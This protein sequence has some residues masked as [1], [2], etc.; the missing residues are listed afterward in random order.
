MKGL[1]QVVP[2]R[3]QMWA[4]GEWVWKQF[5]H[6]VAIHD[7]LAGLLAAG[8]SLRHP[9]LASGGR[10]QFPCSWQQTGCAVERCAAHEGDWGVWRLKLHPAQG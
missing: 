5:S 4:R 1:H 10:S 3:E 7:S 9:C 6:L 2:K 8:R